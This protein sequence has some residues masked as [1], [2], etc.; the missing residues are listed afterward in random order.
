VIT[1]SIFHF[2]SN[3][4]RVIHKKAKK[5]WIIF[6]TPPPIVKLMS[7]MVAP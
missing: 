4:F 1:L 2:K 3:L 7:F 5:F 6:D